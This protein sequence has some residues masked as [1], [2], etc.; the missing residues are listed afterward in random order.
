MWSEVLRSVCMIIVIAQAFIWGGLFLAGIYAFAFRRHLPEPI[1]K[2]WFVSWAACVI[3]CMLLAI[4]IR[5][6]YVVGTYTPT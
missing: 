1:P 4:A 2:G 6:A 5:T 3:M